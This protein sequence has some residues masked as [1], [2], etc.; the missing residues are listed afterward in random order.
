[1]KADV[2]VL[3]YVVELC[4]WV[5]GL[6]IDNALKGREGGR[7]GYAELEHTS[8]RSMVLGVGGPHEYVVSSVY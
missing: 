6:W 8:T 5:V 3:D 1:M 2:L 7:A 4:F